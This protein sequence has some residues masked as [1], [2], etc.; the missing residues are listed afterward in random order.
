M[1]AGIYGKLEQLIVDRLS[2][3]TARGVKV[4]AYP[5]SDQLQ[6][7]SCVFVLVTGNSRKETVGVT[8]RQRR[9]AI[10]TYTVKLVVRSKSLRNTTQS[11]YDLL[12]HIDAQLAGWAPFD[13]TRVFHSTDVM[14][15]SDRGKTGIWEYLSSWQIEVPGTI[16]SSP[17]PSC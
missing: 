9:P 16:E 2:E 12:E 13:E 10:D 17:K 5:E 11:V 14:S 6:M 3:L 8:A 15:F 7:Q 1:N 4:M